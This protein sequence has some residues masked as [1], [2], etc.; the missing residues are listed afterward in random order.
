[1]WCFLRLEELC[2][3]WW[4]NVS[5]VTLMLSGLF[6]RLG[7]E[8]IYYKRVTSHT[9]GVELERF[10]QGVSNETALFQV[11]LKIHMTVSFPKVFQS[12]FKHVLSFTLCLNFSLFLFMVKKWNFD[13]EQSD[14]LNS[15]SSHSSVSIKAKAYS[16]KSKYLRHVNFIPKKFNFQNCQF[17]NIQS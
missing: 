1:M 3:V 7:M 17:V 2:Q 8:T 4:R 13:N 12:S 11:H 14:F 16:V 9:V 5:D 6:F 10:G 15:Q